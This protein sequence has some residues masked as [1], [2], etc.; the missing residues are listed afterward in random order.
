[1]TYK[2]VIHSLYRGYI[3]GCIG[4]TEKSSRTSLHYVIRHES[5]CELVLPSL[6]YADQYKVGSMASVKLC[7]FSCE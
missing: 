6:G 7:N 3:S 4:S 2:P 5:A 1:V